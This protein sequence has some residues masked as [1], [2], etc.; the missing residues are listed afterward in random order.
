MHM[1]MFSR[2]FIFLY[3]IFWH[4]VEKKSGFIIEFLAFSV[5]LLPTSPINSRQLDILA[6][7]LS[8]TPIFMYMKA[9]L[10]SS[11]ILSSATFIFASSLDDAY[12]WVNGTYVHDFLGFFQ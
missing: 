2:A 1:D 8:E 3:L 9:T 7:A 6:I 12:T 11:S 5:T 10:L 4:L